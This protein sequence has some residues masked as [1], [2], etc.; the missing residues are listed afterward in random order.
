MSLRFRAVVFTLAA[1]AAC[2]GGGKKP[3][4]LGTEPPPG[5]KT[6]NVSMAE[7]GLEAASLDKS[8]APC[9]D[10][11]QYTCG[12]WL[13]ANEIPADKARY[14]RFTEIDDR[15]DKAVRAILDDLI[16]NPPAGDEVKQK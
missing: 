6:V 14:A 1:A 15:N 16:A 3:K 10:F 12:G 7:V 11:F 2:G 4:T 13:T 8:A 5:P 9:E